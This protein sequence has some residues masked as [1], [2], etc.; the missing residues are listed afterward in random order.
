MTQTALAPSQAS[1]PL[2]G[3]VCGLLYCVGHPGGIGGTEELYRATLQCHLT[4]A[5]AEAGIGVDVV[6]VDA[7]RRAPPITGHQ[8]YLGMSMSVRLPGQ[9]SLS[10]P[11]S[12]CEAHPFTHRGVTPAIVLAD[13]HADGHLLA[14]ASIFLTW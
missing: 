10:S 3:T 2:A 4:A 6:I 8:V 13:G 11:S 1:G 12:P 9:G 14:G 7:G 5:L